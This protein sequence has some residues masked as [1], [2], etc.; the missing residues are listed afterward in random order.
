MSPSDT[1]P[2]FLSWSLSAVLRRKN[3]SGDCVG[4]GKRTEETTGEYEYYEFCL[5]TN[6]VDTGGLYLL[7]QRT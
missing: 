3:G 7:G 6:L 4:E 5:Q 2:T 1:D